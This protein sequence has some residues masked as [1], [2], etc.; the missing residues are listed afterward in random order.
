MKGYTLPIQKVITKIDSDL[1]ADLSL[2]ALAKY[3][4]V[5]ASYLSG[6]FKK[7]TGT[8]LTEY[9][10]K[11]RVEHGILLLNSTT[12][13]IQTIAQYCGIPDVNYFTKLFK[14]HYNKTPKDYR[15]SITHGG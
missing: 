7:E 9:V 5:N 14:K 6:L 4:N 1:T 13:Q 3:I 12:L 2:T 15:D 8:T 10:N 11:K